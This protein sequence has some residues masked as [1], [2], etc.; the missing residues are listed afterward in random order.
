MA[1]G[2]AGIWGLPRDVVVQMAML[3]PERIAGETVFSSVSAAFAGLGIMLVL[4]GPPLP[5]KI[6]AI[7][8]GLF[9]YGLAFPVAIGGWAH[10]AFLLVG[11][12]IAYRRDVRL[13]TGFASL[14][15]LLVCAG[16]Y[17]TR[18]AGP[19]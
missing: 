2:L 12:L 6:I 16:I 19:A 5:Y 18:L 14:L 13:V 3:L 4:I 7:S 8:A 1:A 15:L 11:G 9:G 17:M 10:C